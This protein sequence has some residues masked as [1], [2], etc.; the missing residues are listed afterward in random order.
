MTFVR[1]RD[2][3]EIRYRDDAEFLLVLGRD[4]RDGDGDVLHR[5]FTLVGRD[6][7]DI[8]ATLGRFG[9]SLWRLLRVGRHGDGQREQARCKLILQAHM[10]P[11]WVECRS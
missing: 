9:L 7:D 4:G 3:R 5:L 8:A 11:P 10:N 2:I 6:D 1:W